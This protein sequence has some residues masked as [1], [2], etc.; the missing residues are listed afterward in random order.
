[1]KVIE[2]AADKSVGQADADM[3][4]TSVPGITPSH[5]TIGYLMTF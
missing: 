2:A 5:S 4:T 1:M 3:P